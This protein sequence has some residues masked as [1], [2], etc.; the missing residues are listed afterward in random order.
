[1][2]RIT[3]KHGGL[4]GL[5][6]AIGRLREA[7]ETG[8]LGIVVATEG[9]TYQ[10]AGALVLLG[11]HGL[12]H[13]F[14]SGGCLEPELERR[15][16]EVLDAGR[17]ALVAFDTRSDEDLVFG[18]A[19]GC[20]GRV[21]LILVPLPPDAPLAR[22]LCDMPGSAFA[23]D[24]ALTAD[25]EATGAG[26]A[27]FVARNSAAAA[28]P[29]ARSFCWDATG[30]D[31]DTAPAATI[32]LRIMP[33][34]QLLLL[35]AGP[36]TVPLTAFAQRLGWIVSIVEHR[37]RWAA[38]ARAAAADDIITIA[39]RLAGEKL[40]ERI[41]DAAIIM[42]HNFEIDLQ[43]LRFC[44]DSALAYVGLLGPPARRDA[45]LAELGAGAEK[46]R[47]RLHAPVGLDLGG[48]GPEAIALAAVAELQQHFARD[49][50][51]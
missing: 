9:S 3:T 4:R 7:G 21:Q 20:R 15:A 5:R 23:L 30:R 10:K 37:E 26:R 51:A 16:L 29:A 45:L 13:G 11:R 2:D 38:F 32:S 19:S 41:A 36:E 22:A 24:L 25:G 49:G 34:A 40:Q 1:M 42:S 14:I 43:H 46:L 48:T 50:H 6:D 12:R 28:G 18:S 27:T 33:P 35:G 8:V 39:P 47:G 44:A 17:A 31:A